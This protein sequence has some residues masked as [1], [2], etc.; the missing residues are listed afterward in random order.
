MNSATEPNRSRR[1]K[2][3]CGVGAAILVLASLAWFAYVRM[4]DGSLDYAAQASNVVGFESDSEPKAREEPE[5]SKSE[6]Q[7]S[8]TEEAKVAEPEQNEVARGA[9]GDEPSNGQGEADGEGEHK[10]GEGSH[11]SLAD[12]ESEQGDGN[13]VTQLQSMALGNGVRGLGPGGMGEG[14]GAYTLQEFAD[15]VPLMAGKMKAS[16]IPGTGD[17]EDPIVEVQFMSFFP[18]YVVNQNGENAMPSLSL[19]AARR[20]SGVIEKTRVISDYRV[21]KRLSSGEYANVAKVGQLFMPLTTCSA[22]QMGNKLSVVLSLVGSGNDNDFHV[23]MN[24]G[25][26]V[27]GSMV[28]DN[29]NENHARYKLEAVD[30]TADGHES[31]NFVVAGIN[32]RREENIRWLELGKEPSMGLVSLNSTIEEDPW[33]SR[34]IT[35]RNMQ[36]HDLIVKENEKNT[37]SFSDWMNEGEPADK[38]TQ[39]VAA[40]RFF[41]E[42]MDEQARFIHPLDRKPD[43]HLSKGTKTRRLSQKKAVAGDHPE[44]TRAGDVEENLPALSQQDRDQHGVTVSQAEAEEL[45]EKK[46]WENLIFSRALQAWDVAAF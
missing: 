36:L 39:P 40:P 37:K 20:Q 38:M 24:C 1:I 10:K 23:Q 22:M 16:L 30:Y 9:N 3:A 31:M 27:W 41:N 46:Q 11:E 21:A 42:E 13:L 32:P 28:V 33:I 2:V 17:V 44:L 35:R 14:Q 6:Q 19:F 5:Q 43:D 34:S 12:V 7:E 4:N 18:N 26:K 29:S 8:A 45:Q 25:S 15:K